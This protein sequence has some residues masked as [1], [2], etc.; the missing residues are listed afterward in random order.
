MRAEHPSR[1]EPIG[2]TRTWSSVYAVALKCVIS[3]VWAL[4]QFTKESTPGRNSDMVQC[5]RR[6]EALKGHS[7]WSPIQAISFNQSRL[8]QPVSCNQSCLG[9]SVTSLVWALLRFKESTPNAHL[10]HS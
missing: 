4:L 2:E 3:L 5:L 1:D 6:G 8:V 10:I 9:P 7:D